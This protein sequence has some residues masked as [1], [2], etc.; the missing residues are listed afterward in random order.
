MTTATASIILRERL[1]FDVEFVSKVSPRKMYEK[2]AAGEIH[3]A[4]EA[5]PAS[6][7]TEFNKYTNLD[8]GTTGEALVRKYSYNNL[9]GR[10]GLFESCDRTGGRGYSSCRDSKMLTSEVLL[11]DALPDPEVREHFTAENV[12]NPSQGNWYPSQCAR[13][14]VNCSVQVMHI[15]P[16]GYDEGQVESLLEQMG[17]PAHV[18]Y[19]GADAHT[20][21]VWNSYTKKAGTLLYS[22]SPNANQ[23]G[24]SILSLPRAQIDPKLDFRPQLL[25]KLAW[26]GLKDVRGGDATA[27]IESFILN[28]DDYKDLASLYDK[29]RDP[30]KAAC[31]WVKENPSKWE[32]WVLFPERQTEPFFCLR[33]ND[34]I[35]DYWYQVGWALFF[36]QIILLLGLFSWSHWLKQGPTFDKNIRS[37]LDMAIAKAQAAD[38]HSCVVRKE[39]FINTFSKKMK[40]NYDTRQEFVNICDDIPRSL[41]HV[42]TYQS[43]VAKNGMEGFKDPPDGGADRWIAQLNRASLLPYLFLSS[44]DGMLPVII[45]CIGLSFISGCIATYFYLV[46]NHQTFQMDFQAFSN[47]T[48]WTA[49]AGFYANIKHSREAFTSLIDAFKFFPSFL[50]IGFLGYAVSRWRSNQETSY[51]ICGALHSTALVIGSSLTNPESDECKMLA[52]RVHRYFTAVHILAYKGFNRWFQKLEWRDFIA[53]GLLTPE[54]TQLL[55]PLTGSCQRETLV[56]WIARDMYEG[57]KNGL[58][59]HKVKCT[60]ATDVRGWIA[61]INAMPMIGQPNLWSALM[62]FVVDL[63]ILMFVF[64]NPFTAFMYEQG[65]FQ[66]YVVV[67]TFLQ[68]IPWLCASK[69]VTTLSTPYMSSHDQFHTDA[70]VAFSEQVTYHN[71]RC[72]FN[73]PY[74]DDDRYT[75]RTVPVRAL[76]VAPAGL[77]PPPLSTDVTPAAPGPVTG[78]WLSC[79]CACAAR[80]RIGFRACVCKRQDHLATTAS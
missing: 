26:P 20:H 3:L 62:K 41:T 21:K 14:G 37:E 49:E 31:A 2:L 67:F 75:D 33:K 53:L 50:Q 19:L 63:L 69:L 76:T 24:I 47:N 1:G 74:S 4:F 8:A 12:Q 56:G 34:G 77:P 58:I 78:R 28:E 38:A 6:N 27:F 39:S 60:L 55:N 80:M 9:F 7:P 51:N 65:P 48:P 18:A 29:F 54:E 57:V 79:M 5:W 59:C 73:F 64:G 46:V 16:T 10:S 43:F 30:H 61:T 25:Q 32:K 52:F 36:I 44:S 15:A 17:V 70:L 23:E 42:R 72:S 22:Y 35:C 13:V 68:C 11:K 45:D 40:G 66:A 71:L